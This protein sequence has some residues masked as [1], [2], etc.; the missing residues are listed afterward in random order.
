MAALSS[1]ERRK[2]E[3]FLGMSSGYVLDF[4]DRT[5]SLFFDEHAGLNIDDVKYRIN[6]SSD[7]RNKVSDYV[8]D[9]LIGGRRKRSLTPFFLF[10]IETEG[11]FDGF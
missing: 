7:S 8:F 1:I 6:M 5:F 9:F 4:S 3:R 11:W 2:L 10:H